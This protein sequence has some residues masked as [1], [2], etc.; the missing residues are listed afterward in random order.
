M[1]ACPGMLNRAYLDWVG[2]DLTHNPAVSVWRGFYCQDDQGRKE[3]KEPRKQKEYVGY[4]K[5]IVLLRTWRSPPRVEY[6]GVWGGA[7]KIWLWKLMG[8]LKNNK[9]R[10]RQVSVWI[11][12]G[13]VWTSEVPERAGRSREWCQK[14]I[15]SY[16]SERRNST[17]T[18]NQTLGTTLKLDFCN[19]L[20]RV[21]PNLK[22]WY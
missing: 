7:M 10:E 11:L 14:F 15:N 18:A 8:P 3:Q 22:Y 2:M 9:N 12:K 20:V 21:Q 4:K 16:L 17:L 1:A 19:D 5:W 13:F 6:R